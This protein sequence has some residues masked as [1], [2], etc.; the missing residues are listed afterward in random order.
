LAVARDRPK[1]GGRLLRPVS[2][3]L[4]ILECRPRNN[5]GCAPSRAFRE[6]AIGQTNA[7]FLI[8]DYLCS[9]SVDLRPVVRDD[10][11]SDWGSFEVEAFSGRE[12]SGSPLPKS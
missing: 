11:V 6:G 1:A 3:S 4:S 5:W 8:R 10:S 12:R 2:L 9:K 7:T